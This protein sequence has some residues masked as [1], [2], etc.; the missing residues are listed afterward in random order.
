[1]VISAVMSQDRAADGTA[2]AALSHRVNETGPV[3]IVK[4][5]ITAHDKFPCRSNSL[6]KSKSRNKTPNPPKTFK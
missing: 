6:R 5:V 1:M 4:M 2:S 3:K